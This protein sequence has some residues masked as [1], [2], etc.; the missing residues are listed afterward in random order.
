MSNPL[1]YYGTNIMKKIYQSK[2]FIL[3]ISTLLTTSLSVRAESVPSEKRSVE[4]IL[5]VQMIFEQCQKN[6]PKEMQQMYGT[7]QNALEALNKAVA[8]DEQKKH[9]FQIILATYDQN[10]LKEIKETT[11]TELTL[12]FKTNKK[13][14]DALMI[15]PTEKSF[16]VDK[17]LYDKLTGIFYFNI[18]QHW[19]TAQID[20]FGLFEPSFGKQRKQTTQVKVE[21]LLNFIQK[22]KSRLHSEDSF[23]MSPDINEPTQATI[24]SNHQPTSSNGDITVESETARIVNYIEK[25]STKT[26]DLDLD[27]GVS[28]IQ[29]KP[30]NQQPR[31]KTLVSFTDLKVPLNYTC[32]INYRDRN[33]S[34]CFSSL[35]S[36]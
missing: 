19:F 29:I 10:K 23:N 6:Y 36:D 1:E 18:G 22:A 34:T 30:M 14:C 4:Q 35:I 17:I 33:L 20:G 5:T 9:E 8:F 7:E 16:I 11:L 27:L 32:E 15:K 28:F 21:R 12:L 24:M 2:Y 3:L 13:T 25:K 26:Q 31:Q